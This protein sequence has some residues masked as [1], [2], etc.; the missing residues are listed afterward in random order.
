M[1]RRS[2][3]PLLTATAALVLLPACATFFEES[4]PLQE[5][6]DLVGR[7]ERVHVE[8][9]I[10][11]TRVATTLGQLATLVSPSYAG[12]VM[13][14]YAQY[15][16]AVEASE[17]HAG[18]LRSA[19]AAMR[20]AAE[21]FFERWEADL[22]QYASTSMRERS[23]GRLAETRARYQ[24]VTTVVEPVSEGYASISA[25]LGDL[26]LFLSHDFNPSALEQ[27]REELEDLSQRAAELDGQLQA[28]M[29]AAREYVERAA[30]PERVESTQEAAP[31]RR[32]G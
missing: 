24:A 28:C 17:K 10:A 31:V 19:V 3:L 2:T 15:V 12:D 6:D 5:V 22:D 16:A 23:L 18:Q 4:V 14:G 9:E 8:C 29:Q 1:I 21:P 20:A 7:V 27:A 26:V 25:T 13:Q 11:R 32:D 30:L